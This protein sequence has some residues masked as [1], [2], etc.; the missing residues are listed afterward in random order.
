M[1]T[2]ASA[3]L[4]DVQTEYL[5]GLSETSVEQTKTSNAWKKQDQVHY[6]RIET[7]KESFKRLTSQIKEMWN[8]VVEE[9]K[10]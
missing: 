10:K 1:R 9:Y 3:A 6:L 5:Y 8:G 4:L 7:E 2:T